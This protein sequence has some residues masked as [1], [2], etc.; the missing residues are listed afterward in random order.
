MWHDREDRDAALAT[1]HDERVD[2]ALKRGHTH[3]AS[4]P[5]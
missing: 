5:T 2:A 1:P 3:R 4:R